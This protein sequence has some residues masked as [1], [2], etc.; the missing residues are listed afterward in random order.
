MCQLPYE[1]GFH[2]RGKITLLTF[3]ICDVSAYMGYVIIMRYIV[4]DSLIKLGISDT[5]I[6]DYKLIF[7]RLY[8]CPKRN[9]RKIS[10]IGRLITYRTS[11]MQDPM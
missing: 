7:G 1:A 11:E 9:F 2:L 4:T 3:V 5:F 8:L 10:S 6:E